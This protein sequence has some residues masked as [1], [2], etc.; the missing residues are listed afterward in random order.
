MDEGFTCLVRGPS[1]R[2]PR[3][4]LWVVPIW[5]ALLAVA[6]V[7]GSNRLGAMPMW[8]AAVEL[9]GLALAWLTVFC[10]MATV[11]R[12][13]FFADWHGIW[14]G[15][16][17]SRKRPGRRQVQ[18]AWPE[19][20]QLR[21]VPRRYGAL[22]EISLGPAARIVHRYSLVSQAGLLLGA[23]LVPV[24]FGRGH[25]ALTTARTDPPRYRVKICDMTPAEL[26]GRLATVMPDG[27]PLRVLKSRAALRFENSRR[28]AR[29]WPVAAA[30]R[31]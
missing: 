8:F 18:L 5:F 21:I 7:V 24:G 6:V 27:V 30:R 2:Y 31:F 1:S 13:A 15:T 4:F 16:R 14:L 10:V 11:R 29:T 26:R 20:A 25:P 17:T 19:V 28:A 12:S 9:G 22:V 23:L 3:G